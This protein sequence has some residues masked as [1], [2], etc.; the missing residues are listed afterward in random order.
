MERAYYEESAVRHG[1]SFSYDTP[2]IFEWITVA[3]RL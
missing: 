2:L 3:R 1:T